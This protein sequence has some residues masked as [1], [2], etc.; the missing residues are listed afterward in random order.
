MDT[1][2]FLGVIYEILSDASIESV[3]QCMQEVSQLFGVRGQLTTMPY[4]PIQN[5]L[6]EKVNG[7]LLVLLRRLCKE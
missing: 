4:H 7:I 3:L 5:W 1:C 6:V 2:S